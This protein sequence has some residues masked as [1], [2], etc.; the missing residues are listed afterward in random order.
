[1]RFLLLLIVTGRND[2]TLGFLVFGSL[3]IRGRLTLM[4]ILLILLLVLII[5]L[6]ITIL[7]SFLLILLYLFSRFFNL[8]IQLLFRVFDLFLTRVSTDFLQD[9]RHI[10]I[11]HLLKRFDIS[12]ILLVFR[13]YR[14]HLRP[15][16]L[17]DVFFMLGLYW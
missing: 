3:R 16:K 12:F 15:F 5:W 6:I 17:F 4:R 14:V 13:N 7:L 9:T 11:A 2:L 1:M 8:L 10:L